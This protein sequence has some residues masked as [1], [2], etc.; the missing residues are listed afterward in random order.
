MRKNVFSFNWE[1]INRKQQFCSGTI[2]ARNLISARLKLK[3]QGVL[4]KKLQKNSRLINFFNNPSLNKKT[5]MHFTRQLTTLLTA[6]IPL[7]QGLAIICNSNKSTILRKITYDLKLKIE[8][9]SSLTA[10]LQQ[11]PRSFDDLFC[12]LINVGEQSG[13]LD[14]ML[15]RI[16]RHY[17]NIELLKNKIRKALT[18]PCAIVVVAIV[19]SAILLLK[20]IPTFAALFT[21][22][23]HVLPLFTQ[24]VIN[25]SHVCQQYGIFM[26]MLFMAIPISWHWLRKHS[27]NWLQRTDIFLLKLPLFGTLLR[28]AI[29]AR[30][31]RTLATTFSAGLPI[32]TCLQITAK[33]AN[34]LY[35][36]KAIL[37]IGISISRG[38]ALH[39]SMEASDAFPDMLLQMTAIGE[40]SGNLEQM[41]N[42]AA[43]LYEEEVDRII[44]NLSSLLEPAIMTILGILIGGLVIA[45]YLPIF[46]IGQVF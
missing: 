25:F 31:C 5:V 12:A 42:R 29:L 33:A 26:I 16:A 32:L 18:Y 24:L 23:G 19:V 39:K 41:I 1:G 17:E 28:K 35:Y 4:I 2:I 36:Q 3:Q 27:K 37:Q 8:N 44:S 9:G 38:E 46:R 22:S 45:M 10:A 13:T 11:H 21:S 34:N 7:I 14:I 6:G 40:E 20:V 15:E 30:F 43:T